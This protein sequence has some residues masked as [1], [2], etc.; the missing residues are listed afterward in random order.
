MADRPLT[1]A[2][3]KVMHVLTTADHPGPGYVGDAVWGPARGTV[4]SAPFARLAGKMLN[5]LR[6]R[7]L[8]VWEPNGH[9]ANARWGWALTPAGRAAL[10]ANPI[11]HTD[12]TLNRKATR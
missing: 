8:C 7:E 1:V 2:E 6:K 12:A 3:R 4:C 10:A 11:D 9:W 5:G